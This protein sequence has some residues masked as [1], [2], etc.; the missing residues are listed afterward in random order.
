MYPNV[1]KRS[2]WIFPGGNAERERA[3]F[4]SPLTRSAPAEQAAIKEHRLPHVR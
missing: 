4:G 3:L 2:Q 1:A